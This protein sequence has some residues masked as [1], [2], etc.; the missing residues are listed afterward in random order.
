MQLAPE[1]LDKRLALLE[2]ALALGFDGI[3]S[4]MAK[5]FHDIAKQND[6]ICAS[7]TTIEERLTRRIEAL[8]TRALAHEQELQSIQ[9]WIKA[10]DK[11]LWIV[12]GIL[13]VAAVGGLGWAIVE[14][15]VIH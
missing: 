4:D 1:A 11:I 2:Q 8:E 7:I 10:L 3:R 13:I 15:G 12:V 14:S 9:P 5:S 6:M